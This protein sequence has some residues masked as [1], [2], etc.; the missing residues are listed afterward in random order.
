MK[1]QHNKKKCTNVV[2]DPQKRQEKRKE[3]SIVCG[4]YSFRKLRGFE[5]NDVVLLE[6]SRNCTEK[7]SYF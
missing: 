4:L 2:D 3:N 1:L 7:R 6:S 5:K